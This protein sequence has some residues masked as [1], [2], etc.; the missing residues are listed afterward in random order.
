MSSDQS[1][2]WEEDGVTHSAL[3]RSENGIRPH[4][5]LVI[6]DDTLT[7][8]AAYRMA[9]EG[10]A[11]LWRGDFQNARQLL[12]A[13]ARRVDKPSKKSVRSKKDF[14]Q[15]QLDIFNLHRL[16]QSQRARTL[17]MLLIECTAEHHIDL[18]RAPDIAQAYEE[19]YG[20]TQSS[21]LVSLRELLGVVGAHEWRKKGVLIPALSGTQAFHIHPH[22]GVFSPIRGEYIDLVNQAPLPGILDS[23]SI[24][25]DI[26]VGTGILSIVLASR[27][28]AKII[29]TDLDQ[30]ALDC[31]KDNIERSNF[32]KQIELLKT[33][34]FPEGKAALIVC[35][36]PWLPARPSSP[37]EGAIYDPNS[38][39]LTGFLSGLKDHLLPEGEAW[40]VLSDLAE[41][42][43]L[44]S[45]EQLQ[46]WFDDAGVKVI[47]R[48]NIKPHHKKVF[49]QTDPL[50]VA[51]SKEVTSLWR[52][53][54]K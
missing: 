38:Q 17:G 16:A 6:A 35:N 18:R 32:A 45:R 41:Y 11:I 44:R 21:Y 40:L 34:L 8:D 51:R 37:L 49:D 50:H 53:I 46:A 25:F 33:N 15:S 52:L 54:L 30:R 47:D 48:M 26:G 29:A 12:Q 4:Q 43:G 14:H 3:W 13:L 23:Y 1:I 27:G 24:A 9:C 20:P 42:L 39:M 10:T 31:A 7:A 2:G 22:Y 19:A 36:P 5:K 28:I